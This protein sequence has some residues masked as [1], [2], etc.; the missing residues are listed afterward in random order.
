MSSVYLIYGNQPLEIAERSKAIIDT[1]VPQEEQENAVFHFDAGDFFNNDQ[2]K[3][4]QLL[5]DFQNTCETV[6]FFSSQILIHLKNLQKIPNRK[7]PTERIEKAL[8][9]IHLIQLQGEWFDAATTPNRGEPTISMQKIVRQVLFYGGKTF[10]LDLDPEWEERIIYRQMARKQEGMELTEFLKW[11]IKGD[12]HFRPPHGGDPV[13]STDGGKLVNLLKEYVA[14]PPEQVSFVFSANIKKTAELNKEIYTN[15]KKSGKEIKTTIAYDDFRPTQWIVNRAK[16]KN[17]FF[18]KTMADLL[19][20][21]AGADFSILDMELSKL[22]LLSEKNQR[23]TPELLINSVSHSK[24]FSIFR[25]ANF[26]IQR[27]LK[28]TLE[29]LE[30]LVGEKSSDA[31]GIFSLIAAQF[32]RA[33]KASWLLDSGI[34]EK[35]VATKLRMNPWL[36]QQLI[37]NTK[38]FSTV[39]LENIVVHLAKLDL[40]TKYS[41][42]DAQA[43]LQNV[44]FQICEGSLR[45]KQ[46]ID[47]Y[48]V[49]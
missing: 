15:I 2:G 24:R 14:S 3:T 45:K 43:I 47:R 33:L 8:K 49:P 32:R 22:A 44:C 39:E 6:S 19:I 18:D 34:P 1:I 26:L 40:Q 16:E 20:E 11:K 37:K 48:W 23:I 9:E 36:A 7:S 13:K 38:Q 31:I 5:A 21:I 27:D 42:K 30:Q 17:L 4:Q 41:A 10:F 12:I 28:G 29:S 46:H 35:E 25:V